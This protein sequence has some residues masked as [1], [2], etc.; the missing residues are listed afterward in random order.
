MTWIAFSSVKAN[1]GGQLPEVR[2][3]REG[4]GVHLLHTVTFLICNLNNAD[5]CM[6]TVMN[7]RILTCQKCD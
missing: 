4:A 2:D 3:P 5:T 1:T 6:Y 7:A